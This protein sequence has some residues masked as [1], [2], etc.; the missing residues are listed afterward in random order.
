MTIRSDPGEPAADPVPSRSPLLRLAWHRARTVRARLVPGSVRARATFAACSV[1]AVA[2][3]GASLALLGL[4]HTDLRATAEQGAREQAEAVARLAADG[5]LTRL[6]PLTHGTDF[7]QVVDASGR[8]LATSQNIA[9]RPALAPRAAP[10]PGPAAWDLRPLGVELH[11]QV[12]TVVATAPDGQVVVHA[13]VSLRAA[14]AAE[15]TTAFTLVLGC[16]LLLLTVAFVTWRVTGRALRPV[17]AIRA[18]VA[19]IGEQ[20]LHHRVPIPRGNDEIVRLAT[21]MNA[22]LDRLDVAGRRQRQFIADA[23]HE[24]RSPIAVLRTQLEVAL[25]HPD[26]EVRTDLLEGALEDTDRLQSLAADLLLLARLDAGAVERP[27]RPVDLA[28]IV[29]GTVLSLGNEPHRVTLDLQEEVLVLG[30]RQWLVRL[31]TNLV[32][33]AQR[34]ARH[35]ITVRV[36]ADADPR[37]SVL[38]VHNDGPAIRPSDRH[39]IFERFTRLDD[40]RSRDHG[41][42]GLGL[43]IAL[44]IAQHHGGTVAVVDSPRGAT[45]QARFP[46]GGHA[47]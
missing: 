30:N 4:L 24:L 21:T 8:V 11:Q 42:T 14:D 20:A 26:P 16:P 22:M 45:F 43:P 9:G 17:E 44:D 5:Q 6:L 19:A 10:G 7:V 31:A 36:Y 1:V 13:G 41:G 40:A 35:T 3:T 27:T 15:S 32:V 18:Q 38:E 39:R 12:T 37:T 23:S 2:L 25:A 28:E 46:A 33:N 34:H 47:V 29:R